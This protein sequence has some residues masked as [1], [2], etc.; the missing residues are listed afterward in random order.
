VLPD[1]QRRRSS[2][3][4][5]GGATSGRRD[6]SVLHE[7]SREAA[8]AA[9]GVAT[10]GFAIID[11]DRMPF[12]LA[13][14]VVVVTDGGLDAETSPNST[15]RQEP[16]TASPHVAV[17]RDEYAE[18]RHVGDRRPRARHRAAIDHTLDR[19]SR[20]LSLEECREAWSAG[21]VRMAEE[22][23]V[24]DS[25]AS[26]LRRPRV[27]LAPLRQF[28]ST[29]AAGGAILVIAAVISLIW[30]N[31]PWRSS[32]EHVWDSEFSVALAGH[33]LALDLRHWVN[34]GLMTVFF[35]V[36][37]LEIKRELVAGELHE[38]RQAALPV[39]AAL[40]GMVVPASLYALVNAGHAGADG[41]GVP[42]ATDIA[43]ALGVLGLVGSRIPQS[44]KLFLLALAIVDD[45]GA[46]VVIAAFYSGGIDLE[47]LVL[48]VA[49]VAAAVAARTLGL[50]SPVAYVFLG[51]V[52]WLAL[53]ES[54]VHAT[55]MGVA[56]GLVAPTSPHVPKD[57]VDAAELADVSTIEAVRR[58]RNLARASTSTVEWL[59]Y[60][61]HPWSTYAILPGFALANAGVRL[62]GSTLADAATSRVTAGVV[63]GLVVGKMVGILVGAWAAVRAGVAVL[64]DEVSFRSLGGVAVLAGIGFTVSLFVTEL[65]FTDHDLAD[66]AR[67]GVFAG[68]LLAG[69]AGTALLRLSMRASTDSGTDGGTVCGRS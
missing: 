21:Q 32:Y 8:G 28:L 46:V 48:A 25:V 17:S 31:S 13:E 44:L 43:L 59:E 54:G 47:M 9:R 18:G 12:G 62:S 38:P 11:E 19:S 5:S 3:G 56:F 60:R 68:S 16:S 1:G 53:H 45:I 29:E 66:Q 2:G 69:I 24:L 20:L 10:N 22:C 58:T 40:G 15:A 23:P 35:L 30:A 57:A 6:L 61:L 26:F 51:I 4:C 67:V 64:P 34:D 50:R 39:A 63:L 65:A 36:A 14:I 52:G 55:L 37:G 41:W 33:T 42:M 27:R 49:A 7:I